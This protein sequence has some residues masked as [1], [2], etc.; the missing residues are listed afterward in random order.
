MVGMALRVAS[1]EAARKVAFAAKRLSV[2]SSMVK[3]RVLM[4][5]LTSMLP[6]PGGKCGW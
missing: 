3:V 4:L 2:V 5:V 6:G 1:A